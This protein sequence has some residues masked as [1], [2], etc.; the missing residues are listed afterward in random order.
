MGEIAKDILVFLFQDS[1]LNIIK[2]VIE[3]ME[4]VMLSPGLVTKMTFFDGIREAMK[5]I[6]LGL[7]ILIVT[8]QSMKSMAIGFGLEAEEP[9]VIAVR[10]FIAGLLVFWLYDILFAVINVLHR[11]I[12]TIL[13]TILTGTSDALYMHFILLLSSTVQMVTLIFYIY[14][15]FKIVVLTFKMFIRLMLCVLMLTL[16]PLVAAALASKSTSGFF[17]GYIKLFVGNIVIQLIQAICVCV[18][19]KL[20]LEIGNLNSG[21]GFFFLI[22]C[23]IAVLDITNKLEDI[24]RDISMSVG[25]GREYQG[26][27][28][29]VQ[30]VIYTTS[31]FKGGAAAFVK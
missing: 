19:T 30:S 15:T 2:P 18:I 4:S 29:K 22:F 12:T 7:L 6:G 25:L 3:V 9:H 1:I 13:D 10:G 5:G 17:D 8:W 20:F 23:L 11:M 24:V 21:F 26:A 27:L 28:A 14:I 31:M 16:S